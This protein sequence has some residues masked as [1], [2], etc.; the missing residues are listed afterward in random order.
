MFNL[1][2]WDHETFFVKPVIEGHFKGTMVGP[3]I[4]R[5]ILGAPVY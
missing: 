2:V 4:L 1:T 5:T 3:L